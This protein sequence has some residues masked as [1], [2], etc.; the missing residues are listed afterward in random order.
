MISD[1]FDFFS[2]CLSMFTTELL[3]DIEALSLK[4]RK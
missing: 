4:L 3:K 2:F 1:D